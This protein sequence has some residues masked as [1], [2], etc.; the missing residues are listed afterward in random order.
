MLDRKGRTVFPPTS[1]RAPVVVV[2][3]L[4][5]TMAATTVGLHPLQGHTCTP[6]TL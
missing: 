1:A 4:E 5:L 6:G 3:N 2:N